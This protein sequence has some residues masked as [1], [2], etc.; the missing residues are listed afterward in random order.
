MKLFH[1]NLSHLFT[2]FIFI[3]ISSL[4][5]NYFN[6]F[7]FLTNSSNSTDEPICPGP[8]EVPCNPGPPGERGPA[9]GEFQEKGPL[10]NL[11]MIDKVVDT[12]NSTGS[13]ITAFL[14]DRTYKPEQNWTLMSGTLANRIKNQ[15]GNCLSVD[16]KD[17]VKTDNCVNSTEWEYTIQGQLKPKTN[18]DQEVKCL[19]Y[20]NAG[21]LENLQKKSQIGSTTNKLLDV[22]QSVYNLSMAKCGDIN[23]PPLNQQWSFN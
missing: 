5:Y 7:E 14:N 13:Y 1:K 2:I 19:T 23:N 12:T 4:L 8:I 10:R 20:T 15:S 6:T 11:S 18:S 3:F 9:G 22:K 17:V 21:P 16:D